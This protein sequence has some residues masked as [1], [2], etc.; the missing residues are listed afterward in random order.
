MKIQ[1]CLHPV[2]QVVLDRFYLF[3][4]HMSQL[5]VRSKLNQFRELP[6]LVVFRKL[7]QRIRIVPLDIN[8]L[9]FLEYTGIPPDDSIFNRAGAEVRSANLEDLD[10]LTNCQNTPQTFLERFHSH[11]YCVVAVARSRIVG[12]QWFSDKRVYVEERY[13]YKIEVPPDTIYTYDAFIVPEYRLTGIWVKFH[14]VYLRN[15]MQRLHKRRIV[16]M[17]DHGNRISM[18]THLRFGY[19]PFC[20]VLVIKAFGKS[21]FLTRTLQRDKAALPRRASLVDNS[22][23]R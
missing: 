6:S 10:G 18:K 19:K 9:Y 17:I 7:L 8:R 14:S 20:T 3:L 4:N 22:G 23:I 1:P 16:T 15:L 21:F 13:S 2:I 11:D 12:Y 5:K